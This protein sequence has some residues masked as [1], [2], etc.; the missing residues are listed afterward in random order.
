MKKLTLKQICK[1]V[2]F[3][4]E[5]HKDYEIDYSLNAVN[6]TLNILGYSNEFHYNYE[7]DAIRCN[8][9]IEQQESK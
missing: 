5:C 1:L 8:G 4:S 3:L 2:D 6:K 9:G 7:N